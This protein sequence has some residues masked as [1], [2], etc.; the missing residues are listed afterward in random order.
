MA[1]SHLPRPRELLNVLN[2][3]ISLQAF[4]ILVPLLVVG[5]MTNQVQATVGETGATY[6]VDNGVRM[7]DVKP[8]RPP[9]G[10]TVHRET[11]PTVMAN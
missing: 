10:L 9:A 8:S 11:T 2:I 6:V 5:F 4:V 7:Y 3:H 1:H